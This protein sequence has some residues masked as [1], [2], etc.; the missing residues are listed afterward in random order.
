[1]IPTKRSFASLFT[2][3]A[4][5]AGMVGVNAFSAAAADVYNADGVS[6]APV[7]VTSDASGKVNFTWTVK[8]NKPV[9]FKY[10]QLSTVGQAGTGFNPKVTVSGSRTFTATQTLPVGSTQTTRPVYMTS[11]GVWVN[12]PAFTYTVGAAQTPDPATGTT[13]TVSPTVDGAPRI[14][15]AWKDAGVRTVKY[16]KDGVALAPVEVAV[17]GNDITYD[18]TLATNKSVTFSDLVIAVRNSKGENLDAG[19]RSNTELH[20]LAQNTTTTQL[21]AGS[22][23]VNVGYRLA[24]GSW[25]NGPASTFTVSGTGVVAPAPEPAPAPDPAPAPA[26]APSVSYDGNGVALTQPKATVAAD[27]TVTF[28]WDVQT[29]KSVTFTYLQLATAGQPGAGFNAGA[30]VNGTKS[31]SATQQFA[32][33]T[34]STAV[35]YM[36]NGAWV[37]GPAVTFTVGAPA[38]TTPTTPPTTTTPTTPPATT[39]PTT[40]PTTG[41]TGT[42][43]MPLPSKVVGGYWMK[44]NGSSRPLAQTDTKY[45]VIYLSF[46]QGRSGTGALSFGQDVQSQTSFKQDVTTVRARGQR[47]I[48]SIGGEG[49]KVDLSTQQRRQELLD[50]L[51][52]MRANEVTFDG[53]DWDIEQ[54]TIDAQGMY[55]VSMQLKQRYGADFAIT[56]APQGHRVEYKQWA[57]LMGNNLDFIGI[58]FYDYTESSQSSRCNSVQSRTNEL[59]SNYGVNPSKIGIGFRVQDYSGNY[60]GDSGSSMWWSI[61]GAKNCWNTTE[62]KYPTLRGAYVWEIEL[63]RKAGGRWINEVGPVVAQ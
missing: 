41:T 22:Y 30:T 49:G 51:I 26:P 5:A 42:A 20:G 2:M 44:W 43:P 56:A 39:A 7:S 34:Y 27:G 21:P 53:I 6:L 47:V 15:L 23:T 33:G 55:W 45:N 25:V 19:Y 3:A 36:V 24:G 57:Q 28:N 12:G 17:N 1:M 8:T 54:S 50:S 31:F 14:S 32:A 9:T 60:V 16:N 63:D 4:I 29:N 52:Q 18:W 35:V 48:M 10:L 61:N 58:Q 62:A 40:P 59:I 13:T 46:A 11:N 37:N 38:A